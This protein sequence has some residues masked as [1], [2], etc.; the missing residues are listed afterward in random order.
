MIAGKMAEKEEKRL[1]W[2]T[3]T[4][5]VWIGL[6][7]YVLLDGKVFI[8]AGGIEELE[9]VVRAEKYFKSKKMM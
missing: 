5:Q 4:N 3:D 2:I 7:A 9:D 8:A 6:K 1:K